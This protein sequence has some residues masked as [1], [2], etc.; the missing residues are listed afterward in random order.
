MTRTTNRL[1]LLCVF[2]LFATQLLWAQGTDLG[3]IRGTV[4]DTNRAIVA[5]ATVEV[6]DV[7]TNLARK[8]ST[9]ADGAYEASAMKS[10][11]YRVRVNAPGFATTEVFDIVLR[12][13]G[14]VRA[15]ATLKPKGTT[16]TVMVK[17]EAALIQTELPTISAT[18]DNQ[19]LTSLPRDSRDIF[20]FLLRR[21]VRRPGPEAEKH[22]LL[23]GLRASHVQ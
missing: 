11:A 5:G 21:V 23:R 22:L 3:V 10:G 17:S 16:E 15:D 4:T 20:S 8:L 12:S 2:L 7:G 6:I 1:F 14:A 19:T 18:L 9:D 13:G